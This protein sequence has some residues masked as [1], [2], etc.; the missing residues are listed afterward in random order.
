MRETLYLKSKSNESAES[1]TVATDHPVWPLIEVCIEKVF[2]FG[3]YVFLYAAT[4][5]DN[6]VVQ[7]GAFL[8]MESH[9]G[10]YR[11][12]YTPEKSHTK[13]SRRCVWWEPGDAPFRGASSFND[14]EWDDR[15]VC[16]DVSVAIEMFR[17]FFDHGDLTETSLSQMY[18]GWDRKA[19]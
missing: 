7:L 13:K 6:D 8:A 1:K 14:T 5:G 10:E 19:R 18:S 17:D 15:T 11:L 4:I 3:G 16:R 2:S 9:L 12:I